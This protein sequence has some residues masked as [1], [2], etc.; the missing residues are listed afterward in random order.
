MCPDNIYQWDAVNLSS[1]T[2]PT[3]LKWRTWC[4]AGMQGVLEVNGHFFYGSHGG[5]Q[6]SGGRCLQTPGGAQVDISRYAIFDQ[7]NGNL[8]PDRVQFD[9]PMG[10]WSF[11]AVPGGLLVGGDFTWVNSTTNVHQGLMLFRGTP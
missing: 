1:P 9:S 8:L 5:D 10:V 4:N 11:A 3:G 7:V 6:G 2:N